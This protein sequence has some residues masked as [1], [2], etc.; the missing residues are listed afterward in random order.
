[1]NITTNMQLLHRSSC[2]PTLLLLLLL[3]LLPRP[4]TVTGLLGV[5]AGEGVG[6]G[7]VV[8]SVVEGAL[9]GC[10]L[11]VVGTQVESGL[12]ARLLR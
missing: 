4:P 9:R 10:S 12:T 7:V 8:R 2:L 6:V 1:M 11:M 3:L 5:G